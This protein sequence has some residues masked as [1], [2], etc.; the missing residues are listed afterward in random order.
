[1]VD[2]NSIRLYAGGDRPFF[3]D[4][5]ASEPTVYLIHNLL[6][7]AEC[8]VLMGGPHTPYLPIHPSHTN[9]VQYLA[10]ATPYEHVQRR[11]HYAWPGSTFAKAV[12]ERIEQVTG[13]PAAH[14]SEWIIDRLEEAST[15]HPHHDTLP[16]AVVPHATLTVVLSVPDDDD[17]V[18]ALVYPVTARGDPMQV[19]PRAGLAVVHHNALPQRPE[20]DPH[21]VHGWRPGKPGVVYLARRYIL[22]TPVSPLR[23]WALPLYT[24]GTH[25]QIPSLLLQWHAWCVHQFGHAAGNTYWEQSLVALPALLLLGIVFGI[26][27]RVQAH[28]RRNAGA[29]TKAAIAKSTTPTTKS[30]KKKQ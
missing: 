13:F 5:E 1:M 30:K 26:G 7:A 3:E 8:A 2:S 22:P 29:P 16:G 28:L 20:W 6:T 10:D 19:Q 15:I 18:G 25:G 14:F 11:V 23:W 12:D 17:D 21:A 27:L 24:A 9:A 4:M